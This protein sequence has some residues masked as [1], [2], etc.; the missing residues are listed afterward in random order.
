[1]GT[2]LLL[3]IILSVG[4]VAGA[5]WNGI[6]RTFNAEPAA[7]HVRNAQQILHGLQNDVHPDTYRDPADYWRV[8]EGLAAIE[9][10]L[11]KALAAPRPAKMAKAGW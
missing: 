7:E 10:R 6:W 1:M 8:S 4:F 9:T 5:A 2:L 11:E 3:A